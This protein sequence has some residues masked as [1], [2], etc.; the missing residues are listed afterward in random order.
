MVDS[1]AQTSDELMEVIAELNE[2]IKQSQKIGTAI[3]FH[4]EDREL[5]HK[6]LVQ[7]IDN[8]YSKMG[9]MPPNTT[10]SFVTIDDFVTLDELK[11]CESKNPYGVRVEDSEKHLKKLI[12]HART[13]MERKAYEKKLNALYKK[14]KKK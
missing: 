2:L 7:A 8:E 13:P 10:N 9:L 11:E 14:R 12:K 4:G 5:Q 6:I 3:I 1:V